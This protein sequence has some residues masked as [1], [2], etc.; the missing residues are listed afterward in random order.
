MKYYAA[1]SVVSEATVDINGAG[2]APL[3]L[4]W[5]DGMVGAIPVFTSRKK[6]LKAAK[7]LKTIVITMQTVKGPSCPAV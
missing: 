4:C 7:I 2:T 1:A 3:K 6:A 5:H